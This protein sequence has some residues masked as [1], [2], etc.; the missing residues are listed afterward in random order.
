MKKTIR[1]TERDLTRLV[2]RVISE[3]EDEGQ[4]DEK[5]V[6]KILAQLEFVEDIIRGVLDDGEFDEFNGRSYK[7]DLD[8]IE[9]S[10]GAFL[11]SVMSTYS[12]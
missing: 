11:K 6:K 2:K 9:T 8:V 4:S 1:L 10:L 12:E 3:Q 5:R 7:L